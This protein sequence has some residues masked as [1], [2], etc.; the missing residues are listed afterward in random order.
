MGYN[1]QG[2]RSAFRV[3]ANDG[4][5]GES[6][7]HYAAK[8]LHA[9]KVAVIDDRSAYG[10]GIADQFIK[11]LKAANPQVTFAQRQFT[12]SKATDFNSILTTIKAAK[13]DVIFF[14]GMDA[15][16]GPMLRQMKALGIKA[17]F[18]GGD[19][20]CTEQLPD[21]AKEALGNDQVICA[22]AG[23]VTDAEKK[24]F[25][26][27]LTAYQKRFGHGIQVY[28][29][30]VYD[31]VMTLADAM[32]QAKSTNPAVYLPFLQKIRHQGVTGVIAFDAKGNLKNGYLTMYTYQKGERVAMSVVK[33]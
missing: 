6:L 10:Q 15:V 33:L 24:R 3:V 17:T 20:I 1:A 9:K 4:Q 8:T 5:L 19:G 2:Y 16:G 22:V 11:G 27:Y 18:M 31:A 32:Q 14:G 12:N 26:G 23:G 29:P 28:S 21:L 13:P 25:D 7:A 30:Y